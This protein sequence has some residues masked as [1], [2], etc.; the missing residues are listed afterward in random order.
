MCKRGTYKII[1][2]QNKKEVIDG[3]IADLDL[4]LNRLGIKTTSSCCGHNETPLSILFDLDDKV[5]EITEYKIKKRKL[6]RIRRLL[7]NI[8][9]CIDKMQNRCLCG[10]YKGRRYIGVKCDFCRTLV[11]RRITIEYKK[12][13]KTKREIKK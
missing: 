13:L 11:E 7:R 3:S 9:H 4:K 1:E 5:Y 8:K 12:W 6:W 2:I 10:K